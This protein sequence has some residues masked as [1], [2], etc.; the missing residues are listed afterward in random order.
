MTTSPTH[1]DTAEM[2]KCCDYPSPAYGAP[3]PDGDG[4]T[5]ALCECGHNH[6]KMTP[7]KAAELF[8]KLEERD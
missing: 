5:D 2:D 3:H 6:G 1:M 7:E 4:T 8:K